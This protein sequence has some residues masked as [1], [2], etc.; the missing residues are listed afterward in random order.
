MR[1]I[2]STLT[3]R[4]T[5]PT[6]LGYFVVFGAPAVVLIH[7]FHEA[8]ITVISLEDRFAIHAMRID[9]FQLL[10]WG[11][12]FYLLWQLFPIRRPNAFDIAGTIIVCLIGC[13]SSAA[14]LAALSLLLIVTGPDDTR[15]LA[16]ATVFAAL[17]TQQAIVPIIH[18][19]L[20]Q[21]MTQFDAV[22]VGS[23]VE[24][25][26][27]GA[28]WQGYII[29]V[30]SGHAIEV[31]PGCCSFTNVSLAFL[32]WVALTKFERLEWHR[33]DIVVLLAA[34]GSQI[35]LNTVRIYLMAMS[36]EMYLYWHLGPGSQIF[37]AIASAAVVLIGAFGARWVSLR[38][39]NR[40]LAVS[41]A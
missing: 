1:A 10:A 36:P 28:T 18:D 8:T 13:F 14:G 33:L 4:L 38:A 5:W 3:S 39:A 41:P 20:I 15:R 25:T 7:R 34:A 24:L 29:T 31:L 2:A 35:L 40:P 12:G 23:V 22:L 9:A 32:S 6:L 27:P 21:K 17:F 30:P 19:L 26:V 37:A 16:A 11:V